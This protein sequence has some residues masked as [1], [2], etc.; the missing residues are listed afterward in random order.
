MSMEGY[1]TQLFGT[2]PRAVVGAI[3][4][5]L[6]DYI[7]DSISC[8]KDHLLAK[9][10]HISPEELE[11]DC[12]LLYDKHRALADRDFDKLEAY[13]SSSVMKIPPH[14]LLEEDSVH[15]HPPSTELKKTELIMLTKAINK[16]IVKQQLLKQ[17]LALQ[18]KVRPQLEG[19]LQRL[20]ERLEILRAMPTQASGS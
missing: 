4:T 6:I 18:Q 2:S 16:E 8:I 14:V 5:I 9:H 17:E 11:K 12:A 20:K 13:I 3:Y 7:T 10:K 19:V 1:E 15:R